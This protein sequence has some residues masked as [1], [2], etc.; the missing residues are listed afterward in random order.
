M[1]VDDKILTAPFTSPSEILLSTRLDKDVG[2]FFLAGLV[3]TN[4]GFV[5]FLLTDVAN[6][7]LLTLCGTLSDV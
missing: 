1:S 5:M 3:N 6:Y 7:T 2:F 4:S